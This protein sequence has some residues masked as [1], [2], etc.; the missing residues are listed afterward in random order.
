MSL[1]SG[2]VRGGRRPKVGVRSL[3]ASGVRWGACKL[4]SHLAENNPLR[5]QAHS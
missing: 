1:L 5:E 4:Q 3:S 2:L